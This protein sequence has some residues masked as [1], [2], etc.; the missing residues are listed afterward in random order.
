MI[1]P[2]CI[3][4]FITFSLFT[5]VLS[6][7]FLVSF[8]HVVCIHKK[9]MRKS[10]NKVVNWAKCD[11]TSALPKVYWTTINISFPMCFVQFVKQQRQRNVN[12]SLTQKSRWIRE[13]EKCSGPFVSAGVLPQNLHMQTLSIPGWSYS[14]DHTQ[15]LHSLNSGRPQYTVHNKTRKTIMFHNS[16]V[17]RDL[18]ERLRVKDNSAYN[19]KLYSKCTYYFSRWREKGLR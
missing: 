13:R 12:V 14:P 8:P 16:Y 15:H 11:S 18:M 7:K 10:Y 17:N 6:L 1:L 19:Q 4:Y 2:S 3:I 5:S 9:M